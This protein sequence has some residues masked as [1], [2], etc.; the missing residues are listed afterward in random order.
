MAVLNLIDS[1]ECKFVMATI[2]LESVNHPDPL[3]TAAAAATAEEEEEEQG[4]EHVSGTEDEG[5]ESI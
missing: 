5:E 3:V 2:S 4:E 1:F